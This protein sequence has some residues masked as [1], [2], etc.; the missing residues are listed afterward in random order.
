MEKTLG[1]IKPDTVKKRVITRI[2]Q[3][4]EDEGFTIPNLKILCLS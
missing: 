4:I 2:L 1:I 3:K